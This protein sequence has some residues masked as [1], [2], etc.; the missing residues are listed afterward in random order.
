MDLKNIKEIRYTPEDI[1]TL[2]ENEIFVFGSNY[3][4]RHGKGA[5]KIALKKF[6]ARAGRGM[7]L[8]GKSYGIATKD[9]KL[10]TLSLDKIEVQINRLLKFAEEKKELTFLVTKIGCGLAG[11]ST[12]QMAT[13][14]ENKN[15]PENVILPKEF[16][17]VPSAK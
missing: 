7:G 8:M 2:E 5:A 4:G 3:A 13:L 12:K 6:G 9:R 1:R 16:H 15:I 11:Y 10:K 17:L 14:F